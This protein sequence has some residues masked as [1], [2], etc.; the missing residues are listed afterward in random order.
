MFCNN[1]IVYRQ[2]MGGSEYAIISGL[3]SNANFELQFDGAVIRST[4][5][6]MND[7]VY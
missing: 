3:N 7:A 5:L 2:C 1:T 4:D 6:L